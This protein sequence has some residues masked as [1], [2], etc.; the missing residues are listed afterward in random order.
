MV[1]RLIRMSLGAVGWAAKGGRSRWRRHNVNFIMIGIILCR[2]HRQ[3]GGFGRVDGFAP[4]LQVPV[5]ECALVFISLGVS[6]DDGP[7]PDTLFTPTYNLLEQRHSHRGME[8]TS[9]RRS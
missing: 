8:P 3:L 5:D 2:R 1:G 7:L 9:G 6:D 4:Q